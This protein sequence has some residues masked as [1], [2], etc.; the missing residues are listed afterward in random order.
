MRIID[1]DELDEIEQTA[2]D[3]GCD[4]R[5]DYS[6]RMMYGSRCLALTAPATRDV[7]KALVQLAATAETPDLAAELAEAWTQDQMGLGVVVYF[8]GFKPDDE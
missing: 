1:H 4:V 6:G 3:N 5:T 2:A 7:I 8:P